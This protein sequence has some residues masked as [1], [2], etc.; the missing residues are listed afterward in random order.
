MTKFK[1]M[2]ALITAAI[3]SATAL[4]STAGAYYDSCSYASF[5]WNNNG[6]TIKNTTN[7]SR[8]LTAY[9]YVYEKNTG[10]E[11]DYDYSDATG[12]YGTTATAT[13]PTTHS[14]M[15]VYKWGGAIYNSAY[16]ASGSAHTFSKA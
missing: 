13:N 1:R 5:T 3:I 10:V 16:P 8:Y 6:C 12:A 15:N 7:T 11:I 4:V 9:M 14:S 2:S